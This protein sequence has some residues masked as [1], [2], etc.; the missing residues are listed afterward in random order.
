MGHTSGR[1]NVHDAAMCCVLIDACLQGDE[2]NLGGG[3]GA[4]DAV[5]SPQVTPPPSLSAMPMIL[6][7]AARFQLMKADHHGHRINQIANSQFS[8]YPVF[9]ILSRDH[10]SQAF[11]LIWCVR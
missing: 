3:R 5:A 8:R 9:Y 10:L 2:F 7:L 4:Q 11:R 1:I 6:G